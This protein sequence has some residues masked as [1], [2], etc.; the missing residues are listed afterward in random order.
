MWRCETADRNSASVSLSP[1]ASSQIGK[2]QAK[3]RSAGRGRRILGCVFILP[4]SVGWTGVMEQARHVSFLGWLL[5]VSYSMLRPHI[6][7][8]TFLYLPSTCPLD[9]RFTVR[10]RA[11]PG[12]RGAMAGSSPNPSGVQVPLSTQ[13][14]VCIWGGGASSKKRTG[15]STRFAE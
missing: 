9:Q 3:S 8:S 11:S 7:K 12:R 5:E 2:E 6:M 15:A 1:T 14:S 4:G 13:A 10:G